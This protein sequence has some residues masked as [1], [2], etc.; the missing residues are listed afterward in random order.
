MK[1][2]KERSKC[3]KNCIKGMPVGVNNEVLCRDKGIV[4]YDFYC[5]RFLSFDFDLLQ[6]Q[7]KYHCSDCAFFTVASAAH[8]H[9]HNYGL[10]SM[11]SVRKYDGSQKKACS[12][13]TSKKQRI[14]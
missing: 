7:M 13:F 5:S 12:K 8:N 4:S 9:N 14:A 11:F 2:N 6:R 10:C 3:C 1:K